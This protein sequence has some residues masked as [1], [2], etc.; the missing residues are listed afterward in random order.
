MIILAFK[1]LTALLALPAPEATSSLML[2]FV[3]LAQSP[4]PTAQAVPTPTSQ[5][6]SSATLDI[7]WTR[8]ELALNAP[9]AALLVKTPP[10]AWFL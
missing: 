5:N 4:T 1:C 2:N 10:S 8:L 9:P 3:L 7:T 6:A